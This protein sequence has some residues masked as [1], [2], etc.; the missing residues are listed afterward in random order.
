MLQAPV[1]NDSFDCVVLVSGLHHLHPQVGKAMDE[2]WRILKPG[3]AFYFVEPHTGSLLDQVR[4]R[5]YRQDR[6]YFAESEYGLDLAQLKRDY[7]T[8]FSFLEEHYGGNL[9]YF[10][11]LQSLILRIPLRLKPLYAPAALWLEERIT[12]WQ[13]S[14]WSAFVLG[15]WMKR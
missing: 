11:V 12:P 14:T 13:D 10:A 7:H 2:I 15:H 4:T 8:R 5:W 6:R 1:P 9:G 3:G